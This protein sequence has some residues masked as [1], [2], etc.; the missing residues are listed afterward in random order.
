MTP[1]LQLNGFWRKLYTRVPRWKTIHRIGNLVNI[2]WLIFMILTSRANH[3]VVEAW[4]HS[5]D[6]PAKGEDRP[7]SVAFDLDENVIVTGRSDLNFYT[8][9][10]S[11][12]NG[13]L[14][15]ERRYSPGYQMEAFP[16]KIA[17][18]PHGDVIVTG[19]SAI[20]PN[21]GWSIYTAKYSSGGGAIL[22]EQV[23][24]KSS[25]VADLAVDSKGDII[26]TAVTYGTVANGEFY[27]VKYSGETGAILWEKRYHS[28]L[29]LGD[30]PIAMAVD[31]DNN[32]IVTG[33]SVVTV[34]TSGSSIK[35][36]YT[37]K[38]SGLDGAVTWSNSY[39]GP[40]DFDDVPK[41][42]AV[43]SNG[44][45]AVT[46]LSWNARNVDFYTAKYRSLDGAVLWEKRLN[47]PE[48]SD[49]VPESIALDAD[50]N[51]FVTGQ[52]P[53]SSARGTHTRYLTAKYAASNGELLWE[54]VM[55]DGYSSAIGVDRA[56]NAVVLGYVYGINKRDLH[57]ASYSGADGALLW[58]VN[59]DGPAHRDDSNDFNSSQNT[60][61][62]SRGDRVAVTA[63]SDN[64]ISN[65]FVTIV[66][67]PSLDAITISFESDG[68][69]VKVN[70]H[71]IAARK[72]FLEHAAD[73]QG[74]WEAVDSATAPESGEMSFLI[75]NPLAERGF[76]RVRE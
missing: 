11:K 22:W 49:D 1:L 42:L 45:V 75:L 20:V 8:A 69:G 31:G 66:Y 67:K 70:A 61:A 6:S 2:L 65:D 30:S 40:G 63:A 52:T 27:T 71:G 62:I 9:K 12:G 50:G 55:F 54:N 72:Y 34:L 23:Y 16:K 33:S 26:V 59:Y 41:G 21:Q 15:W 73:I 5:Y 13:G 76:Y 19:D 47:G 37:I 64:G 25:H 10:Y 68:N 18:D 38:Y 14:I 58:E 74:A 24:S 48:N 7:H 29:S 53:D 17:V 43:D 57:T 32:V 56:G 51:V 44:D 36:V 39:N 4:V 35:D 60:V 28:A 3:G 46:A